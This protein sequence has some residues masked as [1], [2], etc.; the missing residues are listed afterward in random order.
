VEPVPAAQALA[1][2]AAELAP[3][4]ERARRL[5]PGL[6]AQI[7][8]AGLFRLCVPASVGGLEAHP[9]ALVESV[10][11]L[12]TGDAAAG[13]CVAISATSGALAGWLPDDARRDV[14][15]DPAQVVGGVFAP[16]GRAVGEDGALRV[17]GRWPFASGIDHCDW[18]M[19]G[20]LVD[21]GAGSFVKL[22]SGAPDIRLCVV[23]KAEVE[24]L[25]TWSVSGLRATGSHDM[26][27]DGVLVPLERSAS[28]ITD[29]PFEDGPLYAFPVFGL[30]AIAIAAVG[31][32]VAR[33]AIDD[34]T[35]LAGAKTPTGST[36]PLAARSDAQSQ[37]ARATASVRAARA[38]LLEAVAQAFDAAVAT[39]E[40][41]VENRAALRSGASH[42][43]GA[44]AAAVDAMW[45]LAGGSAI[46][47][48][49]PLE[50][51]FRDVHAATQHMLVGPGTFELAGRVLLGVPTNTAQ[52]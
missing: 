7:A 12:A 2:S 13:W 51:R 22:P 45:A 3:A 33:A 24:V 8:E 42:A 41:G 47:E 39:G 38:G 31:L 21:D 40:V 28:L 34:V 4:A 18:L 1:A 17:T 19:G 37:V 20:C 6:V 50:R 44:S 36:R 52:L 15:G 26:E 48:R 14:Y 10:E 43:M 46:Y 32:G 49:T 11:A 25:D 16:K 35:E 9:S 30:L 5:D 27:I 29:P 23:P